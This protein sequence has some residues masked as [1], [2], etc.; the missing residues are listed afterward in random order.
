MSYT[1]IDQHHPRANV[2]LVAKV[3]AAA[4]PVDRLLANAGAG[5]HRALE[6]MATWTNTGLRAT[7]NDPNTG[8]TPMWCDRHH[9]DRRRCPVPELCPGHPYQ[10]GADPTGEHATNRKDQ[11][12]TDHTEMHR[13]L[14]LRIRTDQRIA[15]LAEQYTRRTSG[16]TAGPGSAHCASCYRWRATLTN[17]AH[18]PDGRP[19]YTGLCRW[20]GEFRALEKTLPPL[21]VLEAH[22]TDGM[23]VTKDLV[24]QAL[25]RTKPRRAKTV[26]RRPEPRYGRTAP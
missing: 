22:H 17:I 9:R 5:I 26:S 20:C 23:R 4:E 10:P 8:P 11:A 7:T 12:A 21:A 15:G 18:L 19:R 1:P 13:L 6:L 24:D 14:A 16:A 3:T 25:G 2:D